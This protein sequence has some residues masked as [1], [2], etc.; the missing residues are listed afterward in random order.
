MPLLGRGEKSD[1]I[2]VFDNSQERARKVKIMQEKQAQDMDSVRIVDPLDYAHPEIT[3]TDTQVIE[4]VLAEWDAYRVEGI[5]IMK[6]ALVTARDALQRAEQWSKQISVV[7]NDTL[8]LIR[9]LAH[10]SKLVVDELKDLR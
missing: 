6:E 10:K 1:E 3:E 7:P 2:S 9:E 5:V 4:P 8:P